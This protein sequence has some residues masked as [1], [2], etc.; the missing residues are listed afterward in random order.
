MEEFNF[1]EQN[2]SSEK[3]M[4]SLRREIADL[5]QQEMTK[6]ERGEHYN[7]HFDE[8]EPNELT[9]GDLLMYQKLKEA[10]LTP[11]EFNEYRQPFWEA[12]RGEKEVSAEESS[13]ASRRNFAAWLTNQM[14]A[15]PEMLKKLY[16][17]DF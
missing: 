15:S 14:L 12:Q 11:E 17:E 13:S 7:P 10:T 1:N 3:K 4:E 9:A 6:K 16:P 2:Y 5:K 8:I